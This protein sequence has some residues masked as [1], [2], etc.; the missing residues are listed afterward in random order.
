[1]HGI[2]QTFIDSLAEGADEPAFSA[3]M[4]RAAAALDLSCFAYLCLPHRRNDEAR[5]ISTYPLP[6]S[7]HYLKNHYER[8]DPVIRRAL[9]VTEPFEWGNGI[10][11]GELSD[12]QRQLFEEAARF[13]IR[14][15]FTIP[16][17]DGR[18]PVAAVTFASDEQGPTFRRCVEAHRHVLQLMALYFHASARRKLQSNRVVDGV[19]LSPREY[20]CLEWSAAGKSAWEI[21]RILGITQRTAT[22]HLENAKSKLWVFSLHQAIARHAG[23]KDR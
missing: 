21:G 14:Y 3:A 7:A 1:M 16:I 2:F 15:G 23:S 12:A 17:H 13:G 5:L 22:F 8:L 11:S 20:E 19:A 9:Q 10:E 6:W 18:G 4:A